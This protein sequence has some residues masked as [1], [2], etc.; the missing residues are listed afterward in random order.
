[1]LPVLYVCIS[2]RKSYGIY[3]HLLFSL[4]KKWVMKNDLFLFT[5]ILFFYESI[6]TVNICQDAAYPRWYPS[7]SFLEPLATKW[8]V[9]H[10]YIPTIYSIIY[11]KEYIAIYSIIYVKEYIT[12][13][14]V[15]YVKEYITIY[16]IT[17]AD[18]NNFFFLHEVSWSFLDN[19]DLLISD[20]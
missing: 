14:S 9:L 16:F 12:I 1:M 10:G 15:I 6:L 20:I 2:F 7:W 19:S 13:Y 17:Q 18:K 4:I 11:V 8:G 5:F 3:S